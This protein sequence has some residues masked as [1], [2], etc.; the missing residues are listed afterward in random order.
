MY[1]CLDDFQSIVDF[2]LNYGQQV[3]KTK[4][5]ELWGF[6][7]PKNHCAFSFCDK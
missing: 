3:K 7:Q 4:N 5:T 6:A 2:T 1:D